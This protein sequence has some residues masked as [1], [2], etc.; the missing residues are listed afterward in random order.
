M[1]YQ[2]FFIS[3]FEGDSGLNTYFE[4]F[5]IPEKA[6]SV[7]EDALCWR[8]KVMKRPGVRSLSKEGGATRLRRVY[9]S[10]TLSTKA[11]GGAYSNLD[12]L[13]DSAINV[14]APLAGI[15]EPNAEIEPGSVTVVVGTVTFKDTNKDGVLLV[16]AG[17][18]SETGTINYATGD[19]E[20]TFNPVIGVATNVV[21][22]FSYF[23]GLPC[24]G[25]QRREESVLNQEQDIAFDTKYSYLFNGNAFV[26]LPGANPTTWNGSDAN[27]F[28]VTNYDENVNGN[29][30]WATNANISANCD[31]IRYYDGNSWTTF[32]PQLDA[33]GTNFLEQ[34]LILVPYRGRFFAMNVWEG[35][36]LDENFVNHFANKII[37]S[38]AISDAQSPTDQANG[39]LLDTPGRGDYILLPTNEEITSCSVIRDVLI[40]KCEN[41]SWRILPTGDSTIPF[42]Y[43]RVSVDLGSESPFSMVT[44]DKGVLGLSTRGIT[45]DDSVNV[46]RID[47]KIPGTVF[48][49]QNLLS[50]TERV[51]GIRDF[52]AE[53]VYW[54]YPDSSAPDYA[55]ESS[56]YFPG[57]VLVYNYVNDCWAIY[58]DSFTCY[59]Y[60]QG[61]LVYVWS[62][63]DTAPDDTW[64]KIH[65]SWNSASEQGL[66]LNIIGGNQQGFVSIISSPAAPIS[67]NSQTLSIHGVSYDFSKQFPTQITVPNHNLQTGQFI[68][69]FG[70]IGNGGANSTNPNVLNN[71]YNN[72]NLILQ[73]YT[74]DANTLGLSY[75]VNGNLVAFNLVE[76]SGQDPEQ[77]SYT[78]V[79]IGGGLISVLNSFNIQSK[80]F[81]PFYEAGSQCRLGYVDLFLQKT[82]DG[83]VS[84]DV[85]VDCD[86]NISI[87]NSGYL[88]GTNVVSTAPDNTALIPYQ[89][90][91]D[92]IWH[93]LF[94]Q[95]VAQNF[96]LNLSLSDAQMADGEI[97]A[98]SSNFILHALAFYL[99]KNARLTQ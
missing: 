68:K 58:N 41:S 35:S 39:W 51:Y 73:V 92:K 66:Y 53:L 83:Q 18:D 99:S 75:L 31:P 32:A 28:W 44:F 77:I 36:K 47:R 72:L 82:N 50:G 16:T 2:P 33:A 81:S 22:S 40:V 55:D 52:V 79:Y 38:W 25:L 26:E 6:F 15:K 80:Q 98:S 49:T 86:N 59:G 70:V 29:L 74:L 10:V 61:S 93:R 91:Q 85:F 67:A 62:D 17:V 90:G 19:L 94:T 78:G 34:C 54:A 8:G 42:I 13:A 3:A 95:C 1:A 7:L 11:V 21:V 20:L 56:P 63:Y 65:Y 24:M 14:R 69:I 84:A 76:A 60:Y 27:L 37:F 88:S 45:M 4:P 64:E 43:Q 89:L 30:Y 97:D 57:K 96:S 46:E 48:T 71:S 12:I 23:P 5:L 9:T 87:T